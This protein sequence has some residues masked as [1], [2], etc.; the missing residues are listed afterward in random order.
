VV[1]APLLKELARRPEQSGERLIGLKYLHSRH[2][3]DLRQEDSGIIQRDD[4]GDAG[5]RADDLVVLTVGRGLV[6]DS[7]SFAGGHILSDQYLPRI[8]IAIRLGIGVV[9]E[10]SLVGDTSKIGPAQMAF[11]C[12]RRGLDGVIAEVLGVGRDGVLSQQVGDALAAGAVFMPP[13]RA[14]AGITT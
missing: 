7:R 11:D 4:H 3:G 12:T 5:L 13:L 10:D 8:L 2:I 1:I 14:P 9:V 6:D